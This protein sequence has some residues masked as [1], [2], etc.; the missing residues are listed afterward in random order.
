MKTHFLLIGFSCTGKTSL[1]KKAFGE[2]IDSDDVVRAWIEDKEKQRFDHV[3]EI[4][5]R[6]GRTRA[7]SLIEEVE[8]ALIDKWANDTSPKTISL[9]PGFPLRKN[10][11]R[12]R[13]IS[14]VVL[15]RRS[16]QG[17][18]DSLME[19]REKTFECC[20]EAK[21]HDNWDVDVIVDANRTEFTKEVA[22][23][24]IQRLLDERESVYRDH[25]AEV[26][27]DNA[28]QKLK[29]L[30]NAFKSRPVS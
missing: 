7:L 20:P 13:A 29:E 17:I 2:V 8:K 15:F 12:L 9:G 3:Y 6:L 5:I 24:N 23:S 25:D 18:Y 27:T 1:G 14:Y 30:A 21:G 19:R 11:A 10:W 26:V 4:Y 16:P 28:L 22:I